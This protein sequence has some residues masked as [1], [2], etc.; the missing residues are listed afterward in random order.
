MASGAFFL[1]VRVIIVCENVFTK[2]KYYDTKDKK[3]FVE[4]L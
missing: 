4:L 3:Y 2:T 1:F